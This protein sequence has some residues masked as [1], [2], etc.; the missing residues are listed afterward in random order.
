MKRIIKKNDLVDI[1]SQRTGF[2]KKNM[3]EVVNALEEIILE[4]MKMAKFDQDSEIH[5]AKGFYVGGKRKATCESKD[6][7][8]GSAC[9]TPEKVI[10]YAVFKPSI[11]LKLYTEKKGYEKVRYNN[12]RKK[13]SDKNGGDTP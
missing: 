9:I 3:L 6:P 13:K 11:R 10:P 2:Y 12:N 8:N 4:N 5:L 1:L 7:R